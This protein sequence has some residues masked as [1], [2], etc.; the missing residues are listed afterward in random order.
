MLTA[1]PFSCVLRIP[2]EKRVFEFELVDM[3][4]RNCRVPVPQD[5][6]SGCYLELEAGSED[7]VVSEVAEGNN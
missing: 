1:F 2:M 5:A 4:I 6:I 7:G 3:D